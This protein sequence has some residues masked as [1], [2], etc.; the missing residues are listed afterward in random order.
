MKFPKPFQRMVNKIMPKTD[1]QIE[2]DEKQARLEDW[3][4]KLRDAMEEHET[5][6]ADCATY[7]ALYGGTKSIRPLGASNL[8]VS[9]RYHDDTQSTEDARQVVNLVFQ[10]IESQI[11]VNLPVP[12]VEAK[13]ELDSEVP[14][15]KPEGKPGEDQSPDV[16]PKPPSR[17]DMIEGQLAYMAADTSLRRINTENERITKKNGIGFFKVGYNPDFKAHTYRGRIE[18]TNPHPGNVVLQPGVFRIKDMDRMWHIENRTIDSICRECGKEYE[19]KYGENLRE[20]LEAESLEYGQLD[21]FTSETT[22]YSNEK[23][24]KLSVVEAWEKDDDGDICLYKWVGDTI[25]RE[26]PKFFYK[27]DP[28]GN[29]IEFDEVKLS[30]GETVKVKCHVPD[31]F[32]FVIWFNIPKEKSARGISDPYIIF[33]QQEAVKKLLSGAEKKE[34]DGTTKIFVRKGS[35]AAG[36]ITNATLQIIETEDPASDVVTKD[37]KTNDNGLL[38]LYQI[39]KQAAKDELGIT[40]A[41]QGRAE[42]ANLSGKA[43]EQ[44]AAQTQGRMGVKSEEKDIAYT[45]LYRMWYDFLLAFGDSRMPYRTEGKDNRPIYGFWDK[46][47]LVKKDDAGEY[48]YPE[49]DIYVQAET[50]LPK[51][52]RFILDIA[53]KAGGRLDNIGY[54]MLMESIGVPQASAIL[55][56]EQAKLQQPQVQPGQ[57]PQA[58]PMQAQGQQPAPQQQGGISPELQQ[59]FQVLPPEIQQAVLQMSPDQQIAFLSQ[60][61]EQIAAIVKQAQGQQGQPQNVR[62]VPIT[63]L[64]GNDMQSQIEQAIAQLPPE[65]QTQILQLFKTDPEKALAVLQQ[66]MQGQGGI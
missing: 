47:L 11:D 57:M 22:Y 31:Y 25:L 9:D 46:G 45:E 14:E 12:A 29:I 60:P 41:S 19:E 27:R 20:R 1:E 30:T 13:E 10:L 26:L 40:E 59:V 55:E 51:D 15:E 23:T 2:Q 28:E 53:N 36:K 39:L 43:L 66:V 18:T 61:P 35:G 63:S 42:N 52:K 3:K 54:W 24:K 48:Y 21:Y 56:M 34:V 7:D 38:N 16:K 6:R 44:L 49:F 8:Y 5:F 32:P 4:S 33:D 50:A 58:Q 65:I 62:A 17:R 37:L 64:P